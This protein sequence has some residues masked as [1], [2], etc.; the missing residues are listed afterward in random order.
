MVGGPVQKVEGE[1]GHAIGSGTA[2]GIISRREVDEGREPTEDLG[3]SEAAPDEVVAGISKTVDVAV[4]LKPEGVV[5][6]AV[7]CPLEEQGRFLLGDSG[8]VVFVVNSAD[9]F[10]K[11]CGGFGRVAE[12]VFTFELDSSLVGEVEESPVGEVVPV[13][14]V[15]R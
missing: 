14:G 3:E 2:I 8:N 12:E 7:R 10:S 1:D 13:K 9:A 4:E 11:G 5:G 6:F 15:A